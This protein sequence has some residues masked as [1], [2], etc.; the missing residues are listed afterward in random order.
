[1]TIARSP[2][3]QRAPA[4]RRRR[5]KIGT[6]LG[7]WLF[8]PY[9]A[10]MSALDLVFAPLQRVL[11]VQRMGYFFVLPN[12]LIFGI[13]IL[14]PML[15]NFYYGFTTGDSILPENRQFVGMEN[16]QTLFDCDNFLD[17]NTCAQDRFWRAASNTFTFV[18]GQVGLMVAL[19]LITALAL[20]RQIAGRGFFRSVFF[21][22][23]LISPVVVALIWKWLLQE[24]GVLNGLIMLLGGERLPFLT[25]AS[26]ARFWVIFISVWAQ[27][28][29]YTLILLAGLQAI[30][31][32]LY[33]AASMDGAGGWRS[34]RSV[35]LPLLMPTMLVVLVLSLIRAVQVFDQVY[36][37]TTGGPGTA[38]LYMVQYIF[39]TAFDR[40]DFGLAAA[41]S[42]VLAV[43]LLILTLGQLRLGRASEIA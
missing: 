33:E 11:G 7:S 5:R 8:K 25:D 32:D 22:P 4:P 17:P 3:R 24:Q 28:G 30:P 23:V 1:M 10:L 35:T 14:F 43:V 20:N 12:L 39:Q 16:L 6:V 13:F 2:A 9:A 26:W 41:A 40:H 19:A 34:F 18:V 15:L 37:L 29:F 27:M 42:L 21:Y 36:V 31:K 38:T